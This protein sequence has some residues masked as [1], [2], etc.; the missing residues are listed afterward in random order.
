M[1]INNLL[2][3]ANGYKA[4]QADASRL[5]EKWSASG[6]LEGLGEKE[7]SNMSIMLENQ[8]KQIVAEQSGTGGGAIGNGS[9]ASEQWA[10]VALPLVRKVFAQ[11]SS[12][13]FVSVM[14]LPS[15]LYF[16]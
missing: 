16:I 13:D 14:N 7:S 2:E 1:E 11:I 3:S 10:G 9:T 12:K 6:L 8:A 15:V 4:L 5:A